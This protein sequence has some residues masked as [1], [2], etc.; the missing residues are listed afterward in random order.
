MISSRS[1]DVAFQVNGG[2]MFQKI[3]QNLKP[4]NREM[5]KIGQAA[6]L[7]GS[8]PIRVYCHHLENVHFCS[9]FASVSPE[10]NYI[11]IPIVR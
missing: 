6:W 2:Q 1:D 9:S 3:I 8:R 4:H 5:T 7:C 10:N 11:G